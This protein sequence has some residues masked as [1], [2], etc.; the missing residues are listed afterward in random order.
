MEY[1]LLL[2]V[3]NVK[4][5]IYD[6]SLRS[7]WLKTSFLTGISEEEFHYL[8]Q[9]GFLQSGWNGFLLIEG[10]FD[11]LFLGASFGIKEYLV[12]P[13]VEQGRRDH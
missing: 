7:K 1:I 12:V 5:V 9:I 3:F 11:Q 10:N 2:N 8:K 6:F 13:F 4:K